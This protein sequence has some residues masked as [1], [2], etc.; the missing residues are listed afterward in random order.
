MIKVV[1]RCQLGLG[2]ALLSAGC[3]NVLGSEAGLQVP[4]NP[5]TVVVSVR[6][7]A[8]API[9]DVNV[10]VHDLPN[11]VGSTYSIG[12]WTNGHGV[13]T[14]SDVPAG[15]RR[16]EVTLPIG[17]RAGPDELVKPVDVLEGKAVTVAFVLSRK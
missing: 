1:A 2:V 6:E 12:E 7:A 17:F 15:R 11:S 3:S 16:V 8:G 10:Q 9:E 5:G 14:I 4:Q 13:V